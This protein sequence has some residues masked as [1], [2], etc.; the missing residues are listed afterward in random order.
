M[1]DREQVLI[2]NNDGA[3]LDEIPDLS[4]EAWHSRWIED[5][6]REIGVR[7]YIVRVYGRDC[8][9]PFTE[10]RPLCGTLG[11]SSNNKKLARVGGGQTKRAQKVARK[12]KYTSQG[13][14]ASGLAWLS[15]Q[16]VKVSSLRA[17]SDWR[18]ILFP[19]SFPTC[20]VGVVPPKSIAFQIHRPFYEASHRALVFLLP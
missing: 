4:G 20:I 15:R 8:P 18:Q 5:M 6:S 1:A 16:E 9:W 14:S 12:Q 17:S 11:E 3:R 13:H 19:M 2:W 10:I 7:Q